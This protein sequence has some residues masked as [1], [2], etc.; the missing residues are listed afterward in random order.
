MENTGARGISRWSGVEQTLIASSTVEPRRHGTH[1]WSLFIGD[2][3]F[4]QG[5]YIQVLKLSLVA[6]G[7]WTM[8]PWK[9]NGRNHLSDKMAA[10]AQVML[11]TG[12]QLVL[13]AEWAMSRFV[14][15]WEGKLTQTLLMN[16]MLEMREML[17]NGP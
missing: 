11:L 1:Y 4:N 13:V 2:S 6:H 17:M 14:C 12:E 10:S 5:S 15:D 16:W 3:S 8:C 7:E 9:G